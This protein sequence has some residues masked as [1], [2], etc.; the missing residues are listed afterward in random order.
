MSQLYKL[1][2]DAYSHM[3]PMKFKKAAEKMTAVSFDTMVPPASY[4]LD[5]RFRIMDKYDPLVQVINLWPW[6]GNLS[7]TK[8]AVDLAKIGNDALAE[9]VM[10]YPERFPSAIACLPMNNTDEMLKEADRAIKDLHFRGIMLHTP[11]N[12]KPLDSPE[13]MPLYEMMSKYN[14]PIL[15]HPVREPNY[16]DYKTEKVSRNQIWCLFGW[17]YETTAAMTRLVFS[18]VFEKYPN[19]KIVTHHCGAM[20]PYLEQRIIQFYDSYEMNYGE[21]YNLPRS[22]IKYFK[23]FYNDTAIYG[24]SPALMCAHA[25]CGAEHLLFGCD[26]PYGDVQGGFRNIRQTINAIEEMNIS[27]ADKKKIYEDNARDLL[28]IPA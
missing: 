25:F 21:K 26:F 3:I 20:V 23:M 22:P 19:L 16:A 6:L 9:L 4:D 13:F 28:N 27:E 18:G 10:K 8:K 7:Y 12:D 11:V 14:L 15:L 24:N 1:K 5:T 17:V 2:I